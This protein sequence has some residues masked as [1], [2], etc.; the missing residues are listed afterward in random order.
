MKSP[1][2]K[3][4]L[5]YGYSDGFFSRLDYFRPKLE[6]QGGLLLG[7]FTMKIIKLFVIHILLLSSF[8]TFAEELRITTADVS[9]LR[10]SKAVAM[11]VNL[12]PAKVNLLA[13]APPKIAKVLV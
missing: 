9:T 7:G 11:K 8:Q 13:S 5:G 2:I 3:V 6:I 12:L 4:S 10:A 1:I